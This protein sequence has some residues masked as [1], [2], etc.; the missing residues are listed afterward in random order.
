MSAPPII[1]KSFSIERTYP[2]PPGR[3]FRA[4]TDPVKKRR[5]FA[6]GEGFNV[7]AYTLDFQVGGFERC[8]FRFGDG[9]PVTMDAVYL[10]ILADE[11]IVFGYSMTVG[12]APMSS[13]L[14]TLE[15]VAS[16]TGTLLRMTEHTAFVDGND[17]SESRREGSL[18][19]LEALAKELEAHG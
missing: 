16:G 4:F 1:H 2:A 11:R 15:F 7:D 18:G 5:W 14:G 10:D 13:S 9:P 6:E 12:G 8:R 19:L 17:G 3:V